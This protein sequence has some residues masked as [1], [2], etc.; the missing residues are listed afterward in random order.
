VGLMGCMYAPL[1]QI[2]FWA[3]LLGL[4]QGGSFSVGMMLVV[5]RSPNSQIVASLS[6]MTQLVGYLLAAVGPFVAGVMR[7]ATGNWNLAAGFFMVTAVAALLMGIGAGQ[8][9]HVQ[10]K[11][12]EITTS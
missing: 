11:V 2:W 3:V 1:S 7:D 12:E 9:V 10:A 8:R 6:G 4:G 5:L